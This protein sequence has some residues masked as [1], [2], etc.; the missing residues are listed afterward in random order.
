MISNDVNNIDIWNTVTIREAFTVV[1]LNTLVI[2]VGAVSVLNGSVIVDSLICFR[3]FVL[4]LY[5]VII[6]YLFIYLFIYLSI[7]LFIYFY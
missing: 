5:F 6:F 4:F 1:S 7:H 2:K 3:Y